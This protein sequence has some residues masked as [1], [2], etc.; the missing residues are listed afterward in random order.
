M[1]P[2]QNSTSVLFS[3]PAGN[4]IGSSNWETNIPSYT[5]TMN[6]GQVWCGVSDDSKVSVNS[7][8]DMLQVET[9]SG[10]QIPGLDPSFVP[11]IIFNSLSAAV[12][13]GWVLGQNISVQAG[14]SLVVM[15]TNAL[16]YLAIMVPT[17]PVLI[18]PLVQT[19]ITSLLG[20]EHGKEH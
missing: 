9:P 10:Q 2:A 3:N 5:V 13:T 8:G 16:A 20:R 15:G 4:A 6:G 18:V 11:I 14:M 17:G 1:T 12:T 7:P 19:S